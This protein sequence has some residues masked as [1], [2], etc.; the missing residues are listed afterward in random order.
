M[1]DLQLR[2]PG[3][4]RSLRVAELS[5]GTVRF[6]LWAAALL[7]PQAPSL[8]VLNEPETSLHPD[9]VRPLASLIRTA[10]ARTQVLVVTH[11]RSLLEFLDTAALEKASDDRAIEIEL[12]KEWGETR[13]AG[14]DLL[15]TPRWDWGKR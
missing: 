8:M 1:F 9:L 10:A 7:S 4:L 5:D 15:T 2:Q 13:V 12:Y 14:Q 11:S 3:M 6:L